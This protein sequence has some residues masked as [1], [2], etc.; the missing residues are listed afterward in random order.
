VDRIVVQ[1]GGGALASGIALGFAD[2]AALG[3]IGAG[4]RLDTVQTR[5]GWPLARAWRRVLRD[6]G[7]VEGMPA[8]PD[9]LH[10]QMERIARHRSRYMWPWETEPRSIAHGILDDETYDWVA[11]V[12]AML[13]S[14]GRSVV[15]DEP[16]L[17]AA[18]V[19][20][21]ELTGIDADET[22]TAGLA[23]LLALALDGDLRP[24]ESI[25]V[26]MSGV[27]RHPQAA[28][29]METASSS[30]ATSLQRSTP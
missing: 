13:A 20:A 29:R 30:H 12:R 22:G 4:P 23:G 14:G 2:A 19:L 5:G 8:N 11:V 18:N 10:E 15:V 26:V 28:S 1:V 21:R 7:M 3:V 9:L 16:A 24:D 25:A 6:L 17:I 27:R